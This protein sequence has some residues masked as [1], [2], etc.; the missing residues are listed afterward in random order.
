H[1]F[2][3]ENVQVSLRFAD[4]S[5]GAID[6]FSVADA[7]LGKEHF[8]VF[9]GGQH[10]IVDEFRDKGQAEE[11]RQFIAAVKAGQEM[12]IPFNEIIASTRATLAILQSL[13]TCQ[14]VLVS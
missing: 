4:G 3:T 14:A 10:V 6:Y 12:P 7:A 11:I 1:S 9:G 2:G 8:E 13:Q 5:V